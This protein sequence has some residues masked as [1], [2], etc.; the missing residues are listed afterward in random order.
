MNAELAELA[1]QGWR[2]KRE[3]RMT[4][5]EESTY[6]IQHMLERPIGDRC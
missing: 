3:N 4:N 1:Q 6:M 5:L 2:V